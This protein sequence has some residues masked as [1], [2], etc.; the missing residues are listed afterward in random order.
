MA[1]ARMEDFVRDEVL[2]SWFANRLQDRLGSLSNLRLRLVSATTIEVP[3][4]ADDDR[5]VVNIEGRWRFNDVAVQRAAGGAAG[6][7]GIYVVARANDLRNV[8]QPFSDFTDYSFDL[9]ITP[10]G[11]AP[12]VDPGVVDVLRRVGR[13]VWDGAAITQLVQEMDLVGGARL[14]DAAI[15]AGAGM[16][17][18]RQPNGALLIDIGPGG[19][20]TAELAGGAVTNAEVAAGAAIAESKLAL[21]S[22]A[23]AGTP[24]R[25]SLGAGA[26]QAAPGN[27]ARLSDQRVP[28]DGSVTDAKVAAGAAIAKAK[29]APLAIVDADVTAGAAIAEGKLALASDA[30]AGTP[31]RRTLGAGALQAAAGND[32]RLSDQ[33][34]PTDGSVTNAKVAAGAAIAKSK[35]AAL[36]IVDADVAAGAAIAE[37]KLA[38]ASDA[39]AGTPSR[40]TLGLGAQQAMPGNQA[41]GGVLSGG[42]TTPKFLSNNWLQSDDLVGRLHFAANGRTYVKGQA[43][44]ELRNSLDQTG[45]LSNEDR[46]VDVPGGPLRVNSLDAYT[47]VP[48]TGNLSPVF[49]EPGTS[50]A[51]GRKTRFVRSQTGDANFRKLSL[52]RFSRSNVD[53]ATGHS[54]EVI[55]RNEYYLGQGYVRALV[56]GG[57]GNAPKVT[58]LEASEQGAWIPLLSAEAVVT[59]NVQETEVFLNL[60]AYHRVSVEVRYAQADTARPFTA[61]GQIEFSGTETVLGADP[62]TQGGTCIVVSALPTNP[63]D[64]QEVYYLASATKGVVW[65]LRYRAAS[66]SAYKW[67]FLGGAA[68]TAQQP[69]VTGIFGTG[70]WGTLEQLAADTATNSIVIPLAGDYELQHN[71]TI[72]QNTVGTPH[73]YLAVG[74]GGTGAGVAVAG[75][76]SIYEHGH[77]ILDQNRNESV[78][79]FTQI[80]GQPVNR[81][82]QFA[83]DCSVN[84]ASMKFLSP[85]MLLRPIRVG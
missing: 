38:L 26:L 69:D 19:V 37:A 60:Q 61:A 34:V 15:A 9:R 56:S 57:Y 40:R 72:E 47:D 45:V 78:F 29:L 49:R 64:G 62:G 70:A 7:Y 14:D 84:T 1:F 44:V 32:A 6:V 59:G 80:S 75:F 55:V 24:S 71:G 81:R 23:A 52:F 28:T 66:A 85:T 27:D 48:F 79:G 10:D 67:E 74:Y 21:A 63:Y 41:V 11:L 46:S 58:V 35:L 65:H 50:L 31:S 54:I 53:W 3:A 43:G 77:A 13:L 68:L 36:V 42:L 39:A 5:A 33:R 73:C 4:G 25:R 17:V 30:A 51:A 8:P 83:Y 18:T 76:V 12:A 22:D 16:V 2:P 20:G 82:L